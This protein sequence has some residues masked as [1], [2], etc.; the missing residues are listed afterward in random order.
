MKRGEVR[1]DSVCGRL[2]T[3]PGVRPVMALTFRSTIEVPAG[4]A[5]SRSG[6]AHFGLTPRK[7]QLGEVDRMGRISKCGGAMML[8]AL[9][10]AAHK[11][12]DSNDAVVVAEGLGHTGGEASRPE[13]GL[14]RRLGVLMH[15]MWMDGSEFRWKRDGAAAAAAA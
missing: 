9:C 13:D 11:Y 5:R 4:F 8:T 12:A 7:W 10:E 14:A 2:M 3:V 15:R 1:G 6:G